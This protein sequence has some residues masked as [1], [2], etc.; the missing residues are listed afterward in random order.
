MKQEKAGFSAEKEE[1]FLK[2]LPSEVRRVNLDQELKTQLE[3]DFGLVEFTLK[4]KTNQE[5][6]IVDYRSGERVI[7][8]ISRGGVEEEIE[9]FRKIED[10]LKNNPEQTWIYFSP[11]NKTEKFD[12]PE[13]CVDFWRMVNGEVVWNRMVVKNNFEEMN[14]VRHFLSGEKKVKDE[15]EILESPVGVNLKLTEIFDLFQLNEAK[16]I[17][18]LAEIEKVVAEYLE[19]FEIN[20]GEELTKNSDLIFRLYSACFSALKNK[21]SETEVIIDKA[22]LDMY[23]YGSMLESRIENSFGCAAT[24]IIGNFGERI[25]YFVTDGKVTY[26]EIPNGYKHCKDCGCWYSGEKCPFC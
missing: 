21:N 14:E 1:Q 2:R 3:E 24:T 12:Y 25:G 18:D 10:G 4:Y 5:G 20:F 9:G 13:N 19:E 6:G 8:M 23:M 17:T 16:N 15:M 7:D 26:G 11:K 22:D